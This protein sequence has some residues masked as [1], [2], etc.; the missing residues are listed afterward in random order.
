MP[1]T[2]IIARVASSGVAQPTARAATWLP[3]QAT[4]TRRATL[5]PVQPSGTTITGRPEPKSA[6]T[7]SAEGTSSSSEG[8][9]EGSEQGSAEG[10]EA[11][12][13]EAG[14]PALL[15]QPVVEFLVI[16]SKGSHVSIDLVHFGI[17][18]VMHQLGQLE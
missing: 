9:S 2:A 11:G 7:Q 6:P 4:M 5:S 13:G 18:I 10:T 16:F 17:H 8:A 14:D 12:A 1:A 15:E 3:S